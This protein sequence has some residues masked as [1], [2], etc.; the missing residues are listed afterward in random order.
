[1]AV[2]LFDII[3]KVNCA[4]CGLLQYVFL[5]LQDYIASALLLSRNPLQRDGKLTQISPGVSL[6][7]N[8]CLQTNP[9]CHGSTPS[10]PICLSVHAQ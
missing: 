10:P 1:M 5:L 9:F 7:S 3:F 8:P 4:H 2:F 6:F